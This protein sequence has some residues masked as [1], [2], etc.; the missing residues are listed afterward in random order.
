MINKNGN[1]TFTWSD[2]KE[3]TGEWKDGKQH[4]NGS[5]KAANGKHRKGIWISGT[6]D[7]WLN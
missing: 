5:Y 7:K 4:G 6:R 3:Y 2:G 1:G